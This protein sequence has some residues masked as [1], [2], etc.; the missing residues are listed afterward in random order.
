MPELHLEGYICEDYEGIIA[1]NS[2][3]PKEREYPIEKYGK[4]IVD[5]IENFAFVYGIVGDHHRGLGGRRSYIEDCS[6]VVYFTDKE[7]KLEEAMLAMDTIMYGGD[8]KTRIDFIG[9]S[10]YTITGMDLEEFSIGGHDLSCEFYSHYG[11][12]CHLIIKC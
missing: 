5:S 12:Y 1:L 8:I 9:Y 4:S 6:L 3:D 7:C 2:V 11:E 10:E